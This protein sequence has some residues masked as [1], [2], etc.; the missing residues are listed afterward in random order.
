MA[1]MTKQDR[2]SL[3]IRRLRAQKAIWT[4]L[5]PKWEF[6]LSSYEGGDDFANK[7]NLFQHVREHEKDFHERSKRIYYDNHIEEVV[8][9]FTDFIFSETID[10]N[11][12]KNSEFYNEF[13][14]DVN[15]KGDDITKFMAEVCTNM[16]IYG[17]VYVLVDTPRRDPNTNITREQAKKLGIRPYWV[18][19]RPDEITDWVTDAFD[20]YQYC[21]R[22]SDRHRRA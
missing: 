7:A 14:T 8:D 12:G 13:I 1:N 15:K 10:R 20:N 18:L 3:E 17:M 19:L 22:A 21:K 2:D 5:Q 6:Y 9:F 11:G 16:Q 4:E